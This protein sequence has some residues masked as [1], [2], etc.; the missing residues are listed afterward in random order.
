[1]A[2][3]PTSATQAVQT[4]EE[5]VNTFMYGADQFDDITMM[6]VHRSPTN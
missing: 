3:T 1:L 5:N 2:K 6:A 4:I